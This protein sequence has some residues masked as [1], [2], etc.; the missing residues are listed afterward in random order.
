[1]TGSRERERVSNATTACFWSKPVG[2]CWRLRV[3][4]LGQNGVCT[5]GIGSGTL[6]M[7]GW[8]ATMSIRRCGCNQAEVVERCSEISTVSTA[9]SCIPDVDAATAVLILPGGNRRHTWRTRT[10]DLR[11]PTRTTGWFTRAERFIEV[12]C[13]S[14]PLSVWL[15]ESVSQSLFSTFYGFFLGGVSSMSE[16]SSACHSKNLTDVLCCALLCTVCVD[17]PA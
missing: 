6:L 16:R 9:R 15:L 7:D 17:S 3:V 12:K 4:R 14:C 13:S 11:S 8:P 10:S 5:S 2:L 1:M